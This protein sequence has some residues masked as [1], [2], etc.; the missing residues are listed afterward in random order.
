MGGYNFPGHTE[1]LAELTGTK[2]FAMSFFAGKLRVVLLSTHVSLLDAIGLVKKEKL[3]EL[4]H[5]YR[6]GHYQN[7]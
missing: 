2:E 3:V 7:F 5:F 1:F 6:S 4:I